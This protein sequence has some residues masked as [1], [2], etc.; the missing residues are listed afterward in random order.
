M[1]HGAVIALPHSHSGFVDASSFKIHRRSHQDRD[2]IRQD[3]QHNNHHHHHNK[4]NHHHHHN[5]NNNP[6]GILKVVYFRAF[7]GVRAILCGKYHM[8]CIIERKDAKRDGLE[9][10]RCERRRS[11]HRTN[12]S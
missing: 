6:T 10:E 3:T 11:R 9:T 12:V 4:N 7:W 5:N 8:F 1:Q 2:A